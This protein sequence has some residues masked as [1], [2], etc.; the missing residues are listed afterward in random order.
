VVF[1]LGPANAPDA[2]TSK[3]VKLSEGSYSSLKVL[4][5]GVEGTQRNQSFTVNY[6]DGTS[7]TFSQS[8][9]DWSSAAERKGEQL[10]VE[11]PYRLG[12]DGEKDGN[13]FHLFAYSFALDSGKQVKSVALPNN[14]NVVVLAMTLVPG[15]E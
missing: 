11:M 5:T 2:V 13:P 8:V 7:S 1:R 4:A 14:R 10:A 15:K 3:T 6:A 12:S 9:S